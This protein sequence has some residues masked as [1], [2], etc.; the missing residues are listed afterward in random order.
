MSRHVMSEIRGIR[1][2]HSLESVGEERNQDMEQKQG[3][4]E[5]SLSRERSGRDGS[6]HE[7]RARE[8]EALTLWKM[9]TGGQV[10]THTKGEK[11]ELE[12]LTAWC[13][14]AG[15]IRTWKRKRAGNGYSHSREC[16]GGRAD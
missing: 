4:E 3:S 9:Q 2:T 14:A 16:R 7:R 8:R 11:A 15:Q 5:Y 6:G 1:G 13:N 10:R 12:A